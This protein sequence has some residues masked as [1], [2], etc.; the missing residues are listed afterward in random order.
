MRCLALA[1]IIKRLEL[2]GS[3]DEGL[4]DGS[5]LVETQTCIY[6]CGDAARDNRENRPS[7]F[8]EKTVRSRAR[9]RFDIATFGLSVLHGDI[10]KFLVCGF[11][12]RC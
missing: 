9:L 11:V 7:K 5:S 10:D 8:D 3:N 1:I 4:T 2:T 6:F 12:G